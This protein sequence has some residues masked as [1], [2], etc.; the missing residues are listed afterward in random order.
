MVLAVVLAVAWSDGL[1]AERLVLAGVAAAACTAAVVDALVV[2]Q[3]LRLAQALVWLAGSTYAQ[4]RDDMTTLAPW[5]LVLGPALWLAGRHLDVL[6]LGDDAARG[7]GVRLAP[8]RTGAWCWPACWPRPRCRWWGPSGSSASSRRTWP[9]PWWAHPTAGCCPSPRSSA[10]RSVVVADLLGRTLFAPREIPS[11][12]MVAL[13][14]AP[15]F[16]WVLR[17]T[18]DEG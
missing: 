12:L 4:D 18:R 2:H 7:L 10:P 6:G 5:L 17:H 13:V 14:G 11:G 1:D 15:F 8:T 3:G 9:A 16:L